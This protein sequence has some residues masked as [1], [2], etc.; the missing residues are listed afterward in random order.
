MAGEAVDDVDVTGGRWWRRSVIVLPLLWLTVFF[1]VPFVIL[2][3]IALAQATLAMPPYTPLFDFSGGTF[4]LGATLA[5]FGLLIEDSLYLQAYL[6][7]LRLAALTTIVC[8]ALGLPMALAIARAPTTWRN[9]LLFGV[10]LPFW[11]SFLLRVYAWIGLLGGDGPVNALLLG[12]G[13]VDQPV[14]ILYTQTALLIGMIYAY[15]PFMVLP[16]YANLERHD[17]RLLEAAADLGARPLVAFLRVTLP[18]AV[19]GIIAGSMLVFI[20][21]V[22]EFVIPSLLGGPDSLMIGRVL[23]DEFFSNRDWPVAAAVAIVL[24]LLL[25]VPI[26][27]LQ[28]RGVLREQEA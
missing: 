21:A 24:T 2:V 10:M 16:L 22:G 1:A 20:P 4:S 19:P 15:L 28:S 7:S 3:K 8:L 26:I 6:N 25:V 5:N 13:L 27:V 17:P 14:Q 18:A 9:L 11:T 12:A 23:W